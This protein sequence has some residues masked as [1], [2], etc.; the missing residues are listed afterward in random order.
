MRCLP[1]EGT[2]GLRASYGNFL[3]QAKCSGLF[4]ELLFEDEIS[5]MAFAVEWAGYRPMEVGGRADA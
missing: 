3:L 2:N 1:I 4:T 5:M